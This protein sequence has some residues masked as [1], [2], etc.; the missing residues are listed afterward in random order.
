[1]STLRVSTIQDTAGSNS[2]TPA[3]IANGIAKAWIRKNSGFDGLGNAIMASFNVSSITQLSTG[4]WQVNFTNAMADTNYIV[5]L[6]G[7]RQNSDVTTGEDASNR[8]TTYCTIVSYN[9]SQTR[10]DMGFSVAI[11]R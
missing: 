1:M 10:Y 7:F 9:I 5:V 11:F 4:R 3:A 6:G 8:T 2:S